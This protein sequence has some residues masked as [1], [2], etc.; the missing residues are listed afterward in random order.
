[1]SLIK[2]YRSFSTLLQVSTPV[3][4]VRVHHIKTCEFMSFNL[5]INRPVTF[6]DTIF[7]GPCMVSCTMRPFQFL[8]HLPKGW[9]VSCF[10][11]LNTLFPTHLSCGGIK[12]FKGR[13]HE[14]RSSY[15]GPLK[16][17]SAVQPR[18]KLVKFNWKSAVYQRWL[19]YRSMSC[20]CLCG[21][22][23][24]WQRKRE[25]YPDAYGRPKLVWNI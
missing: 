8:L 11:S 6:K 2:R 3:T 16:T 13:E 19:P 15:T 23:C 25:N 5:H 24:V 21:C 10:K 4:A 14:V 18:T 12:R 17:V 1:M 22:D 9:R 7:K 20:V